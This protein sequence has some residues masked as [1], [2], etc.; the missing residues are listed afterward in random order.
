MNTEWDITANRFVV[1]FDIL[2]FKDL[3]SRNTHN[4]ILEKL[5]IIKEAIKATE[6]VWQDEQLKPY[7]ISADQTRTITFSDSIILFSKGDTLGDAVKLVVDTFFIYKRAIDTG[8]PIKGAISAGLISVDFKNSLFFGQPIIDAYLLHEELQMLTVISDHNFETRLQS[9]NDKFLL[10][11]F[12]L[13]K[14]NLRS[15]RVMHRIL[16]PQ[17]PK[18]VDEHVEKIRGHYKTVSGR[19]RIYIDN[20]IEFL[21]SLPKD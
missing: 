17:Y 12:E 16:K 10:Q 19:P 3:V 14:A 8:I 11:L 7:N 20:T 18:Y 5:K 21:N 13:Y 6:A 4:G 15:G 1:F 2:G 9:L